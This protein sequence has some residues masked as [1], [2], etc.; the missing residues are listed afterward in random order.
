MIV[1]V[2]SG[3]SS[4]GTPPEKIVHTVYASAEHLTNRPSAWK[5]KQNE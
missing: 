4:H 5:E 2:Q 3:R 1:P